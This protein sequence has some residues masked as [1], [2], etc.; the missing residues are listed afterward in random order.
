MLSTEVKSKLRQKLDRRLC[1]K[2]AKPNCNKCY[3]TGVLGLRI[4]AVGI[5]GGA[6]RHEEVVPCR[7]VLKRLQR[8]AKDKFDKDTG[9]YPKG[10]SEI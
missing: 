7:C 2:L 3:G 8:A 1:A 6:I 10:V 5:D 4:N 9:R